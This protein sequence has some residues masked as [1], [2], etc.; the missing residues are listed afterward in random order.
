MPHDHDARTARHFL[1]RRE[2]L[3]LLGGSAGAAFLASYLPRRLAGTSGTVITPSSAVAADPPS[4]IVRPQQTEGPYFVDE[5]LNRSDIRS[6]PS[7]GS[8]REGVPLTL[9][10][11]VGRIEGSACT[12][13]AGVVVDVWHCDAAGIYSDVQDPHFD[14]TGRK[15]LRGYQVTI[16]PGWYLGRT[17]HIHF[18]VRTDPDVS[19]GYDFTSQLYFADELSDVVFTQPPYAAQGTRTTR[20]ANDGIYGNSGEELLLEPT[21]D[22]QGG[23]VAGFTIGL[24]IGDAPIPSGCATASACLGELAAALP[25]PSSA[26]SRKARR[27]ARR[28]AHW[29]AVAADAIAKA[30]AASGAKQARRYARARRALTKL[31][32]VSQAAASAGALGVALAPIEA[33]VGALLALLRS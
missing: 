1:G 30:E 3:A 16:Y 21:S 8:V 7:D 5:R 15:Y 9:R 17:V 13:L 4:C 20:N 29:N 19:T 18:K 23:Y 11:A 10:F 32:A 25:D 24:D 6:D 26:T 12:A 33:A 14:T 2:V 31:R 22:G 27:R 28:I